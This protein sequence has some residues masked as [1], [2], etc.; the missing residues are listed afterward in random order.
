[1]SQTVI[2][3]KVGVLIQS[4]YSINSKRSSPWESLQDIQHARALPPLSGQKLLLAHAHHLHECDGAEG[5]GG[6]GELRVGW[7]QHVLDPWLT[8]VQRTV[9]WHMIPRTQ[10]VTCGSGWQLTQFMSSFVAIRMLK[11]LFPT[12]GGWIRYRHSRVGRDFKNLDIILEGG[13]KISQTCIGTAS[14]W[15]WGLKSPERISQAL[16]VASSQHCLVSPT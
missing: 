14:S 3:L 6:G 5:G 1:M 7:H 11:I 15:S 9:P 12:R 13:K 16:L 4:I 8:A 2:L 10:R